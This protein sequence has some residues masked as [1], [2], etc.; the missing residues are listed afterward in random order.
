MHLLLVEDDIKTARFIQSE[1]EKHNHTVELVRDGLTGAALA[2][3]RHYDL[4][5]VDRMLPDIDGASMIKEL[6]L[7]KVN[8]PTIVLSAMDGINHRVDGLEAGADDYLVKPFA[9]EELYARICALARRPPAQESITT[10][11][12]RGLELDLISRKVSYKGKELDLQSTE[13]RLLEYLMRRK[14]QVVTRAMLLEGVWDFNFDPK[15]SIVETHISRL[16]A[17]IEMICPETIISTVRGAGY[18][19]NDS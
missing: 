11:Q 7:D 13:Y 10:F 3:E 5:I 19:V 17:K 1:L 15:T 4:L 9:F 8:T 16:R 18:C 2:R 14:G 6:R 12:V